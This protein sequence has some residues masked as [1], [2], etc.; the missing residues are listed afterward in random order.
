MKMR[1]LIDYKNNYYWFES[2]VLDMNYSRIAK[3]I[4]ANLYRSISDVK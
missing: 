3:Q 1:M 4:L 2:T